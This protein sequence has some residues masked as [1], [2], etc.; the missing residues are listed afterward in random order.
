MIDIDVLAIGA[1]PDDVEMSAGGTIAKLV[2]EGKR[3]AVVDCTRG[4][5][6]TR[7]TATQR[8]GEAQRASE[9]LGIHARENLNMQ[10]G[11]IEQSEE[12]I[13]KVITVLR[14]YRPAIVIMPPEHE[15]HPDHEA[16]HRL[17]RTAYFQSG[18][19]KV[20]THDSGT[21]QKPHR[22]KHM[23]C[24][25]QSYHF[26]PQ[27]FVDITETQE[28]KIQ[29]VLAFST[30]VHVPGTASSNEPETFISR[31]GFME[32]LEVRA[33]YFGEQIGVRYAEGFTAVK[34]IGVHSMSVW[35]E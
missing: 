29:S 28:V 16:V 26:E 7:G 23:F 8:D 14:K 33:R 1:H 3:V 12:N 4:E 17:C 15:R 21:E 9:I 10:D 34:P 19:T 13:R 35:L 22:P 20:V 32:L 11:N 2:R 30:Q 24:Y 27:F 6:G 31:P 18:L 5:M 25:M